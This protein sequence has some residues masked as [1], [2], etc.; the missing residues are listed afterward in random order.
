MGTAFS[1][2]WNRPLPFK[3]ADTEYINPD[4]LPGGRQALDVGTG[5]CRTAGS[6]FDLPD[7][8]GLVR[9]LC[10]TLTIVTLGRIIGIFSTP[11]DD[12]NRARVC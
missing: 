7:Y 1:P 10:A 3:G 6:A 2:N 8:G 4:R 11:E 9:R 5:D 12:G